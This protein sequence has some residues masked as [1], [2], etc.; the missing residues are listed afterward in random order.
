VTELAL[1]AAREGVEIRH[2]PSA[3]HL[4]PR[5]PGCAL[6]AVVVSTD[7]RPLAV[8]WCGSLQGDFFRLRDVAQ[9]LRDAFG[10]LGYRECRYYE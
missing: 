3:A 6:I 5:R 9:V 4:T 7:F 2:P 8:V 1:T 10:P